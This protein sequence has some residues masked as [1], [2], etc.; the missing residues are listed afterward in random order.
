[1]HCRAPVVATTLITTDVGMAG[2]NGLAIKLWR[3]ERDYEPVRRHSASAARDQ[4]LLWVE[5]IQVQAQVLADS[6]GDG[7]SR[8]GEVNERISDVQV[9]GVPDLE[10][11]VCEGGRR[12]QQDGR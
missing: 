12:E 7:G 8:V 2:V 1:M 6:I 11:V 4:F 9:S 10:S 3:T 5:R